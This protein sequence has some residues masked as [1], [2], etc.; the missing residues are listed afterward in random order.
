MQKLVSSSAH[1]KTVASA[2]S[3]EGGVE[4]STGCWPFCAEPT[5]RYNQVSL[6]VLMR[7]NNGAEHTMERP[8]SFVGQQRVCAPSTDS[9]LDDGELAYIPFKSK[10]GKEVLQ[11]VMQGTVKHT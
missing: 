4:Q 5:S 11:T 9:Q 6:W 1:Q 8:H 3:T 7:L 10:N 2:P